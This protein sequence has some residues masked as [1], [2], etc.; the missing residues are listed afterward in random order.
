MGPACTKCKIVKPRTFEFFY[1]QAATSD[2]FTSWCRVCDTEKSRNRKRQ[3]RK[4][5]WK[6]KYNAEK[7]K[8]YTAKYKA[9]NPELFRQKSAE[10]ERRRRKNPAYR[11][12]SAVGRRIRACLAAR[13]TGSLRHLPYSGADLMLHLERQFHSG[14]SWN[15]YGTE[16]HIDHIVPVSSFPWSGEIDDAFKACWALSNLRP[17]TKFEN[18]SKKDIRTHLL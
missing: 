16:W 4:S 13:R 18:L 17:L 2:G 12:S 5:G 3:L 11:A 9:K 14:M 8:E 6:P 10:T 1:R 7:S 15:N